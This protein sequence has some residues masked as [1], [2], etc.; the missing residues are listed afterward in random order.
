M[1]P[2][3]ISGRFIARV[4][5]DNPFSGRPTTGN[6]PD[7]RP[8]SPVRLWFAVRMLLPLLLSFPVTLM[9]SPNVAISGGADVSGQN[10]SWKITNDYDSPI[11]FVEIPQYKAAVGSPP[12][13]WKSKLT[14]PRGLEGRTGFF[15]SQVD[16]AADGIAPGESATFG[17]T[18]SAGGTPRGKGDVLIRFADGKET[19]VRVLLLVKIIASVWPASRF[20]LTPDLRSPA[21]RNSS[22]IS[23]LER[24]GTARK[25]RF[26]ILCRVWESK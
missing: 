9:G 19:R 25:S 24:S 26:G 17:L 6:A 16:T 20:S 15:T 4:A 22:R 14:N 2:R 1:L 13:G 12:D 5:S 7:R 8:I 18:V 11:I 3:Q 10:Y 23:S 21:V